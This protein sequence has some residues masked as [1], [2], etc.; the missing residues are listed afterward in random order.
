MKPAKPIKIKLQTKLVANMTADEHA[1]C[2]NLHL[3]GKGRIHKDLTESVRRP[4]AGSK[5]IMVK[6]AQDD[7]VLSWGL[8]D[9][10]EN[11]DRPT[12]QLYTRAR[13]RRMGYGSMI[14]KTVKALIGDTFV[15]FK[16]DQPSTH[17]FDKTKCVYPPP[18]PGTWL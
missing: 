13:Y 10:T 5:V 11:K 9:Y 8:I 14:I 15:H 17:F 18:T 12:V 4:R 6:D 3:R 7:K 1:A 2:Y 16:H